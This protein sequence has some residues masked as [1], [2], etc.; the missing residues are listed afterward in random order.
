MGSSKLSEWLQTAAAAGVIIGLALVAYELRMSNRIAWEVA[1]VDSLEKWDRVSEALRSP[2]TAKLFLSAHSGEI[3][4][5][6]EVLKLNA[7]TDVA[8][9]TI[10]HDY[11]LIQT[12]TLNMPQ[13]FES[14]Y[15]GVIQ[16]Y[17]GNQYGQRRWAV[18]KFAWEPD[19]VTAVDKAL[20]ASNQRNIIG[21]LDFV[22]G[23]VDQVN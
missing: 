1:S 4:S 19:F 21:E 15:N 13:G 2:N 7:F 22:R 14:A 11:R 10:L 16:F 23:E 3:L 6:E 8:M 17:L 20:A 12:G 18:V 9:S 5:R